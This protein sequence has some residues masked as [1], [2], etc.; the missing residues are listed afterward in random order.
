MEPAKFPQ[1]NVTLKCPDEID[2]QPCGDLPVYT[3]GK[4][5]V[6]LWRL[7]WLDRL[8]A[9]FYGNLWLYLWTG[10]TQPPVGLIM[11]KTV[12]IVRPEKEE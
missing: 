8:R 11:D 9:L 7:T 10:A 3:D 1:S 5:C 2:G 4:V 6:S 12:F